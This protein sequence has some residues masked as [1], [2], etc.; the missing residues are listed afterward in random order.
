MDQAL[1]QTVRDA[2]AHVYTQLGSGL[3]ETCYQKALAIALQKRG[4]AV[5]MEV[6]VPIR[7]DG[8]FVGSARPDLVVNKQLVL[9]LKATTRISEANI[10]QARAYMRWLPPPHPRTL[11]ETVQRGAVINFGPTHLEI[12][13][14]ELP[15][16]FAED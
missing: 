5:D 10:M 9:E 6:V 2:A 14:V 3:T 11:T 8:F 15:C 7:Y 16:P 13:P 4:C 1:G 12:V